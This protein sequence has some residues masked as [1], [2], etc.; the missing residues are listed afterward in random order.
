VDEDS[1]APPPEDG[2]PP[3]RD[4][5]IRGAVFVGLCRLIPIPFL[6]DYLAEKALAHMVGSI[7]RRHERPV[8][9]SGQAWRLYGEAFSCLGTI[10]WVVTLPVR[11]VVKLL[12]KLF[13]TIFLFLAI[14]EA[15]LALGRTVLLGYVV[16]RRLLAGGFP[17]EASGEEMDAEAG[18]VR[19][20]F[21]RAFQGS[22]RRLVSHG[23]QGV[24]TG[25]SG[26][27]GLVR[28][29]ARR[30]FGQ[31]EDVPGN[32]ALEGLGQR[33]E[34]ALDKEEVR[35]WLEDFEARFADELAVEEAGRNG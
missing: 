31:R 9:S 33:V 10:W 7:F 13:R 6:D 28:E 30:V 12:K 3:Y 23:L 26:L 34:A 35:S 4:A 19:R 11:L 2:E 14:R 1:E 29:G 16:H 21:D 24:F 32:E 17:G 25:V 22:D 15:A 27:F 18:T 8:D 20:A 5:A